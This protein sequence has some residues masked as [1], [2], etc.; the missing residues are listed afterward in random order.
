M[1]ASPK[2]IQSPDKAVKVADEYIIKFKPALAADRR[3]A[4][5]GHVKD[6]VYEM[7]PKVRPRCINPSGLNKLTTIRKKL[8]D[9]IVVK[10]TPE[11]LANLRAIHDIDYIAE[12]VGNLK[13][14]GQITEQLGGSVNPKWAL[15]RISNRGKFRVGNATFSYPE[16]AGAGVQ[17]FIVDSGVNPTMEGYPA[18]AKELPKGR[19]WEG[20]SA[21]KGEQPHDDH[22]GHGI[23]G[24]SLSGVARKS[25]LISVKVTGESGG[26]PTG[27]VGGIF[28]GL[29]WIFRNAKDK[30]RSIINMSGG[31]LAFDPLDELC[32]KMDE[33]GFYVVVA[34]GQVDSGS[35]V[36]I[37]T[38][39][40]TRCPNAL[41]VGALDQADTKPTLAN[42]GDIRFWA[43]GVNVLQ[44]GP[45]SPPSG[46]SPAAAL[47]SGIIAL[48]LGENPHIT[49]M[50][51]LKTMW[52]GGDVLASGWLVPLVPGVRKLII[53]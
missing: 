34:S 14:F 45:Y 8:Y 37:S 43:P 40:P 39:S 30:T 16:S 51:L 36:N 48:Y 42:F 18:V 26:V 2:F 50:A 38:L 24:G 22:T 12:N 28:K 53:D 5:I 23:A 17:I 19:V 52:D 21:V 9:G 4:I 44:L 20:Y 6:G 35:A 31:G 1:S 41:T 15:S 46:S 25:E 10:A 32:T 7:D 27:S 33:A 13:T 29:D 3:A 11:Q 47:V 49:K